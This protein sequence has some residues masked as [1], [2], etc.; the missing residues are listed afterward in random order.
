MIQ[1]FL[2]MMLIMLTALFTQLNHPLSM[3]FLLLI[4]T[5]MICIY[6][7][8]IHESFWFSYILF[9]IF[10]GG[11]L[12][13]F[14]YI[15]SLASNEMFYM[16]MKLMLIFISLFILFMM[17]S[18]LIDKIQSP[19]MFN[20]ELIQFNYYNEFKETS[21]IIN[22]LYNYPTNLVTLMLINYLFFTLIVIVKITNFF[23]GPLRNLK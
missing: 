18:T 9:L 22:K 6:T 17:I 3:G 20:Q 21:F 1:M 10:L 23:Y 5:L 13:L 2:N 4:Q 15:T 14:I 19:T 8:L 12:I 16:S 11:L 7:G